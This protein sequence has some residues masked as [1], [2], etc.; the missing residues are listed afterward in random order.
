VT[1]GPEPAAG[2]E[3]VSGPVLERQTDPDVCQIRTWAE[4]GWFWWECSAGRFHSG[5]GQHRTEAGRD[6]AIVKHTQWLAEARARGR[7]EAW[8]EVQQKHRELPEAP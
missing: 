4:W 6:A 2:I 7:A 8:T 5:R 1:E 3:W